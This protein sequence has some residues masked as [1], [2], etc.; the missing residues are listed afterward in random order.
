MQN[1]WALVNL[2]AKATLG[3]N[4][5]NRWAAQIDFLKSDEGRAYNAA[6]T[7]GLV[8]Y[9]KSWQRKDGQSDEPTTIVEPA[10]KLELH[11]TSGPDDLEYPQELA[12]LT[13]S[14]RT[15]NIRVR[16]SARFFDA[17]GAGHGHSDL[18]VIAIALGPVVIRELMRIINTFLKSGDRKIRLTN[19]SRK[20]EGSTKDIQ[21]LF[22][23]EQLQQ[24]IEPVAARTRAAKARKEAPAL[25]TPK[26]ER[27]S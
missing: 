8:D 11:L 21:A 7:T 24:F 10:Q 5:V 27:A 14:L 12:V 15:E 2:S 9:R 3:A 22:T 19:G 16:S 6:L 1:G 25:D 13:Q 20:L 18:F 17:A 26:D 4:G 23:P